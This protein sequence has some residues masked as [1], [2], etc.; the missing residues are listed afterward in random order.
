MTYPSLEYVMDIVQQEDLTDKNREFFQELMREVEIKNTIAQKVLSSRLA[1][2]GN[3]EE[4]AEVNL[5]H[6]EHQKESFRLLR[7][8]RKMIE[9][10]DK[11]AG[12][13]EFEQPEGVPDVKPIMEKELDQK[14]REA[15]IEPQQVDPIGG[16]TI[17]PYY[18]REMS[19]YE[20]PIPVKEK[21]KQEALE[22]VREITNGGSKESKSE[23][24]VEGDTDLS[25]DHEGLEPHPKPG[26]P[27]PPRGPK[28]PRVPKT[29]TKEEQTSV[30]ICLKCK[31]GKEES[32]SPQPI[33][34]NLHT[35]KSEAKVEEK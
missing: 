29:E 9:K 33:N 18:S 15:H 7:F 8:C 27:K 6:K 19:R 22:K 10:K 28:L 31:K 21:E 3:S 20:P 32:A 14:L 34:L 13:I 25:W 23:K 5:Q 12:Y 16:D 26:E 24:L 11:E 30:Q 2:V 17:P 1:A 4:E 35:D